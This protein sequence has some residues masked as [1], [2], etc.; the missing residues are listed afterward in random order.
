MKK[1]GF[2]GRLFSLH[3]TEHDTFEIL[4]IKILWCPALYAKKLHQLPL[5]SKKID[6]PGL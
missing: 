3:R 4:D 6:K 5:K 1:G 2:I